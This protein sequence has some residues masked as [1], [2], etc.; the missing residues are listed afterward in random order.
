ME[1]IV[2]PILTLLAVLSVGGSVLLGRYARRKPLQDRL[3]GLEA[4]PS[5]TD[6]GPSIRKRMVESLNRIGGQ[7][8]SSHG[9]Q[10]LRE[11][12]ARAGFHSHGAA[13]VYMGAKMLS[14]V[15]GGTI[16]LIVMLLT[17]LPLTT[18]GLLVA[19]GAG[20]GFFVPNIVVHLRSRKR[21]ELVRMHLPD[22]LDLLEICISAGMGLDTAW[23][24]V[25]EEIRQ[26]CPTLADEMALTNLEVHLGAARPL[27][28]R[29]MAERTGGDDLSSLVAIMVQSDRF[30]TSVA[31]AL[32]SFA[33]S[34][35]QTRS[36][37]AEERAEKMAVKLL[38]PMVLFI[39]PAVMIVMVG[40]AIISLSKIFGGSS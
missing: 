27:A 3:H 9:S 19:M 31:S 24:A 20:C 15:T 38:A 6:S 26:V 10:S 11:E 33:A 40:S 32:Q 18:G 21:C 37:R 39:F 4:A 29:H 23:N 35:R 1:H 36:Q 22:A 5:P 25:S 17:F 13:K 2:I 28:L 7:V 12:L 30:G 14:L 34:M 16:M 8:G